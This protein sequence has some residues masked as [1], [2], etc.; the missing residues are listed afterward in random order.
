MFSTSNASPSVTTSAGSN[1][2]FA[3]RPPIVGSVPIG[4]ARISPLPRK[5]SARATAHTSPRVVALRGRGVLLLE[6]LV[7]REVGYALGEVC[8]VRRFDDAVG[9]Q[10]VD[11]NCLRRAFL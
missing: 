8:A 10:P 5:H 11:P 1:V 6:L 7:A 4:L 3:R 9:H 2:A